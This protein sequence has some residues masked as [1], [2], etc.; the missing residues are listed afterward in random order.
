MPHLA[1]E[2]GKLLKG[3]GLRGMGT[4]PGPFQGDRV[5]AANTELL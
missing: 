4:H 1:T 2:R 3:G 5:V